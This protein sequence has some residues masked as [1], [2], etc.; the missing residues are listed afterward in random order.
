MNRIFKSLLLLFLTLHLKSAVADTGCYVR[1]AEQGID[2]NTLYLQIHSSGSYDYAGTQYHPQYSQCID[3]SGA[4]CYVFREPEPPF[5]NGPMYDR[6]VMVTYDPH[7]P[8]SIDDF[9]ILLVLPVAVIGF[10]SIN[11]SKA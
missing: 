4:T 7:I 5:P 2:D 10:I 8:C 9:V 3:L 1:L 6:G 11:K